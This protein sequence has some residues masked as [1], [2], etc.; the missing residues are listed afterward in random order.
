MLA[1]EGFTSSKRALE[2]PRGF[3]QVASTK[4]DWNEITDELGS[5]F[6]IS[7]NTYK[8]F[9]CGIVIHPAI[10][11]CAQLRAAG[12]K[13]DDVE[14]IEIAVHSLVL[15]LT[16]KKEPK[17][18][19]EAKFS[20]YHGCAVGLLFGE[21]GEGEFDDALVNRADVVAIRR[22]VVATVDPSI[23]E[24]EVRAVA[25]MKDD[26]R[27]EVHV[28]HAIGSLQRPLTDADLERK[29]SALVEPVLGGAALRPLMDAAWALASAN[30]VRALVKLAVPQA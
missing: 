25:V 4:C 11:A 15:E 2:A 20:V 16:G 14:R 3:M 13:A 23:D 10:D 8:P 1:R 26:S 5:R 29:F 24:A 28:E 19:L 30:D 7:F 22:K 21:A 17:D 9:A 27:K 6:E 12:V 18:G